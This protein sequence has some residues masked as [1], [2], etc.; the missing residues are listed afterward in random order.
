ML[1][2]IARE[3]GVDLPPVK[4]HKIGDPKALRGIPVTGV[5]GGIGGTIADTQ[6]ERATIAKDERRR[7]RYD[8]P[9]G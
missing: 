1:I 5:P 4:Q 2:Q 7:R 3:T 9:D 6:P 8:Q